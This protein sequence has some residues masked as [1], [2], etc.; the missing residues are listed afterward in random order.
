MWTSRLTYIAHT[1]D[2][3]YDIIQRTKEVIKLTRSAC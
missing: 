2:T 1:K 3:K